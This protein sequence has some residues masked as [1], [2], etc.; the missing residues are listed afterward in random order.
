MSDSIQKRRLSYRFGLVVL[1][2]LAVIVL[3][4]AGVDRA[5]KTTTAVG[6]SPRAT[7][8]YAV[9]PDVMTWSRR[10]GEI[11]AGRVF[12][13]W[14]PDDVRCLPMLFREVVGLRPTPGA[15]NAWFGPRLLVARAPEGTGLCVRPGMLLRLR[16]RLR[17]IGHKESSVAG[18]GRAYW[19]WRDGFLV[20]S[21]SEAFVRASLDGMTP[22]PALGPARD[23]VHIER[24]EPFAATL[25]VRAHRGL[26]VEGWVEGSLATRAR[27]LGLVE[28]WPDSP[29]LSVDASSCADLVSA[30]AWLRKVVECDPVTARL[31][32][33]AVG[34]GRAWFGD[35][36]GKEWAAG[37]DECALAV[38]G[39]NTAESIPVP[40]VG[41]V[42]RPRQMEPA[43][44][45]LAGLVAGR[46]AVDFEWQ[47]RPGVMAPLAGEKI[48]LCLG[49][50]ERDWIAASREPIMDRLAAQPPSAGEVSADLVVGLDWS[51]LGAVLES[52]LVSAARLE[53]TPRM[54]GD[55]A[56]AHWRSRAQRLSTLGRLRLMGFS[57]GD[58]IRIT[59]TLAESDAS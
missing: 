6:F 38:M 56:R 41:L 35:P 33:A 2:G 40:E 24:L 59:G 48:M 5:M 39:I 3:G 15:W 12:E 32:Q 14:L 57:D 10:M 16:C 8:G 27:P 49:R 25:D 21:T 30:S 52:V 54:N 9:I 29:L 22:E 31:Y 58:R 17:A 34:L 28:C 26:P 43:A 19:A 23:V 50:S 18:D 1:V 13:E 42:M 11:E 47:G 36:L 44:H 7:R 45:P 37:Q 20:V 51:R 55:E 4:L 53:L 46:A